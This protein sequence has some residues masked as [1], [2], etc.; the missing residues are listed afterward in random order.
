[1]CTQWND[2]NQVKPSASTNLHFGMKLAVIVNDNISIRVSQKNTF[3]KLSLA[4]LT[5][6]AIGL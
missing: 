5:T 2:K 1:M 4:L 6:H 3:L